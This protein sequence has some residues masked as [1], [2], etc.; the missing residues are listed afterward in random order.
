MGED[1]WEK[2]TLSLARSI[3]ASQVHWENPATILDDYTLK[4]VDS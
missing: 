4:H 1:D 2:M 3:A